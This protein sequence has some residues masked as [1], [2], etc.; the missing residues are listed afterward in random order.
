MSSK[1]KWV[2]GY[3][4]SSPQSRINEGPEFEISINLK[5]TSALGTVVLKNKLNRLL[6]RSNKQKYWDSLAIYEPLADS[7]KKKLVIDL[8]PR[9]NRD[10]ISVYS[11]KTNKRRNTSQL[12]VT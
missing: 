10:A 9:F 6:L 2:I 4:P 11:D 8:P 3:R 7:L 5:D 1:P 12:S